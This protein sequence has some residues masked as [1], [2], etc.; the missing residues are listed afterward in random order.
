MVLEVPA[1]SGTYRGTSMTADDAYTVAG[2]LRDQ[3]LQRRRRCGDECEAH[4]RIG[5]RARRSR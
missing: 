2:A 1:T 5:H 4:E 3:R